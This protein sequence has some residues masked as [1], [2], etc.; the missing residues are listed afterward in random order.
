MSKTGYCLMKLG[1]N[2]QDL[3]D[4]VQVRLD[5]MKKREAVL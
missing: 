5:L 1:I 2:L 3:Q 4:F